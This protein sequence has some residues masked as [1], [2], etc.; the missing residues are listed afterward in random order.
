[1][2]CAQ[3]PLARVKRKDVVLPPSGSGSATAPQTLMRR[4][5]LSGT[6]YATMLG[7]VGQTGDREHTIPIYCTVPYYSSR[8]MGADST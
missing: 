3:A 8:F 7:E 5:M 4:P 2:P 6:M 1:M